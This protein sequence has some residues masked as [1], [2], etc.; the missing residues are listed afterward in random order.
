MQSLHAL[1][2]ILYRAY[3]AGLGSYTEHARPVRDPIESL[4]GLG[5]SLHRAC[6][7]CMGLYTEPA[8][9]K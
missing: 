2:G 7:P 3:M 1:C 9:P 4:H 5:G 8:L 6:T